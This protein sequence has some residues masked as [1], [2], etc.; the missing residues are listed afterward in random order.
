MRQVILNAIVNYIT[1]H[2]YP[3]TVREI[4]EMTALK[5]T[6]SVQRHLE[7]MQ[8]IGMIETDAHK[9]GARAIRIPGYKFV[10]VE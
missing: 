8:D 5:S 4:C 9:A 1:E 6:N 10:K 2:G 7:K 3:P